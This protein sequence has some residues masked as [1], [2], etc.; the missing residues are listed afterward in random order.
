[1]RTEGSRQHP[2]GRG[3]TMHA[4]LLRL[5]LT[6]ICVGGCAAALAAAPA[7]G[8]GGTR[9]T[10]QAA[11]KKSGHWFLLD[12]SASVQSATPTVWKSRSGTAYVLWLRKPSASKYTYDV[13]RIAGSGKASAST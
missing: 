10:A 13:S 12:T 4:R 9:G 3:A 2:A 1:M 7:S 5:V 8:A 11:V 6:G